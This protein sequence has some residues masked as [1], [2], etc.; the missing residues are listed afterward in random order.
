MVKII[1]GRPRLNWF[2]R[3]ANP[4][5]GE[6]HQHRNHRPPPLDNDDDHRLSPSPNSVETLPWLPGVTPRP[7]RSR[8]VRSSPRVCTSLSLAATERG[9]SS[10]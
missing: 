3:Q 9:L 10:A 1:S 5:P 8:A 4:H 2:R 6:K 7:T